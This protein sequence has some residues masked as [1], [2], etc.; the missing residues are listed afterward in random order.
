MNLAPTSYGFL[1]SAPPT[2]C[3]LATFTS[4]LA[5]EFE[6]AG[7]IVSLVRVLDIEEAASPSNMPLIGRLIAEDRSTIVSA[8]TA[9]NCC[10]V[11]I[12]QHEYGLYGGPDGE[13]VLRVLQGLNVP[14]M[15]ILHT[16]LASPTQHQRAVLNEVIKS[17]DAVVVMTESA[18]R[19][20]REVFIV[21]STP[22]RR[23]PHG[24]AVVAIPRDRAVSLQP[25]VL[26]WGLLGPG[27]GIEWAIE[28][29]AQLR[30]LTPTPHYVIAGRTHPKVLAREGEHYRQKLIQKVDDLGITHMVSFDNSYRDS[31]SLAALIDSADVV[32]LPYDSKD[33]ATSGVLVDAIAAGLPVIATSFPHAAELLS[34]GAGVIVDRQDPFAI[35]TALRE[36]MTVPDVAERMA[37]EARRVAAGLSWES[38]A[39]QYLAMNDFLLKRLDVPA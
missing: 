37:R 1:S 31:L 34:S 6:R 30:D 26:T 27:K 4:A 35:A 23:I 12:V 22:V 33:Q 11:V 17:V 7:N 19:T 5:K 32:V 10:D 24:A 38:V 2:P 39:G 16:V 8:T 14:S 29:M 9:L 15:A 13:D 25:T 18:E 21:G 20:L 3:G 36:I 28:A